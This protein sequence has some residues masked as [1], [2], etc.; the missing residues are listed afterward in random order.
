VHGTETER[1]LGAVDPTS[2][3]T[4]TRLTFTSEGAPVEAILYR[5]RNRE[6][7]APALVVSTGAGRNLERMEWLALPLARRGYVVL[8]QRYRDHGTRFHL[9]DE[10]DIGNAISYL[11]EL[12]DVDAGRVGIAGHSRGGSAVLRAAA[13][14]PRVRSTAALAGPTDYERWTR[15]IQQYSPSTYSSSIK[16]YGVAP[17]EDPEYFRV[18]S[19]VTYARQITTPVLIVQG[20]SDLRTPPDHA[21]WMYDALVAAGHR[22]VKLEMLPG[23]G[24]AFEI[25]GGYGFDSVVEIVGNWFAETL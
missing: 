13:K 25:G 6:G 4:I 7:R 17:D 1:E 8:S 23:M 22:R 9:R 21:Q 12:P 24:H 11:E 15:G 20:A 19:P 16:R 10:V 2:E 18:I 14:D 5:R 3:V